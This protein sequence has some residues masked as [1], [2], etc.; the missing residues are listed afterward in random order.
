MII[1]YNFKK[2][3]KKILTVF[4]FILLLV[5]SFLAQASN[6]QYFIANDTVLTQQNCCGA[7]SSLKFLTIFKENIVINKKKVV[8]K[9]SWSW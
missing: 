4:V 7:S 1:K 6:D 8:I 2:Q 9:I 5:S 3:F